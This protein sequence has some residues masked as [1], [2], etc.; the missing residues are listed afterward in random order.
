MSND[1]ALSASIRQNLLSLQSTNTLLDQTTNRL[2]TGREVNSVFDDPINFV[3]S[4]NLND[5]AGDL[6]RLL[7]GIGQ[8]I[9]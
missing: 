6:S 2:A 7:D 9:R 1:V 3:A 4:Q 8:N 5:Q